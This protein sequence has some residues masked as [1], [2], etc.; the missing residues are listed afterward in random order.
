VAWLGLQL[1]QRT[2]PTHIPEEVGR[3][4][5]ASARQPRK[6]TGEGLAAY[7]IPSGR[8]GSG[9]ATMVDA[10]RALFLRTPAGNDVWLALVWTIAI[11]GVFAPLSA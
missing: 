11:I 3:R 7:A 6:A 5:S 10:A 8:A 9:I 2:Q 1:G 4:L